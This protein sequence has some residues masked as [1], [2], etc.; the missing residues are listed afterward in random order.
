MY[1]MS[2]II[3]IKIILI[4]ADYLYMNSRR[5]CLKVKIT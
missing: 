3:I 1:F 2:K 4:E 5:I